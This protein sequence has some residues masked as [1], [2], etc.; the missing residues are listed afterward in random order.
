VR[1]E[2]CVPGKRLVDSRRIAVLID[3]QVFRPLRKAKMRSG[4]W[5]ARRYVL[6][7]AVRLRMRFHRLRVRRLEPESARAI[8]CADQHLQEMQR[9]R[10]LETVGMGRNSPHG[11]ER[12]RPPAKTRMPAPMYIGP[13]L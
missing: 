1:R 13:G 2:R 4:E 7:P 6:G 3:K 10:S 5:L 11:M 8:D 9:P 12:Y